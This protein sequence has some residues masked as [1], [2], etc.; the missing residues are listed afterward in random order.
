MPHKNII[1]ASLRESFA[2]I[3]K[4]RLLFV[5]LIALEIIFLAAFF[6]INLAY[7]TKILENAKAIADYISQ[8]QLDEASISLNMLQQKSILGDDPLSIRRN[9]DAI[10]E[11]FRLYLTYMFAVLAAFGAAGWAITHKL[12]NATNFRHLIKDFFKILAILVFCLGLIFLFFFSLIN[13]SFASAAMD[14]AKLLAKYIPFLIFSAVLAYFMLVSAALAHRTELKSI[15]QKALS[16]GVR[17]AH[18]ILGACFIN[19]FL[20]AASLLLLYYSI[21]KNLFI[22]L[23]S[24]ILLVFSFVFGRIF[25]VRVVGE[26]C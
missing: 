14:S 17:K 9:L 6:F 5:F 4:N 10:L 12:I 7:Q 25:L 15:V 24:I 23:I 11:N 2:A 16:I 3:K 21:E 26:L 20:F 1:I 19:L 13:I 22:A 8:Q 18:Y